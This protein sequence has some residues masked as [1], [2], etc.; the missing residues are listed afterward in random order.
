[1]YIC[2]VCRKEFD[3]EEVLVKHYL[4]CWKEKN[5]PGQLTCGPQHRSE[6]PEGNGSTPFPGTSEGDPA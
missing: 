4:K 6:K 2:P 1:M 5:M 3:V